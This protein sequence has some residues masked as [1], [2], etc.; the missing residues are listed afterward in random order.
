MPSRNLHLPMAPA[1]LIVDR[2]EV[3]PDGLIVHAHGGGTSGTCPGCGML[4]GSVHSPLR[5]DG[6]SSA[7]MASFMCRTS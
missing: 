6:P 5:P 2:H 1:G 7:S 4:S 3:G